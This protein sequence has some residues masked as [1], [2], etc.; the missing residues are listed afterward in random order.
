MGRSNY[1]L[2]KEEIKNINSKL[3]EGFQSLSALGLIL[4]H[5]DEEKLKLLTVI[6]NG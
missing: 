2:I 4:P 6:S 3:D 5:L 1:H